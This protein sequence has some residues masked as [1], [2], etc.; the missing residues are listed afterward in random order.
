MIP[1]PFKHLEGTLLKNKQ[2]VSPTKRYIHIISGFKQLLTKVMYDEPS[3]AVYYHEYIKKG[4][5]LHATP[6]HD[7]L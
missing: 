5:Q 2:I 1:K 3:L 7:S 6:I 4:I